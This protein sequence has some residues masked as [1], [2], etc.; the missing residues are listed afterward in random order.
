[1]G[2]VHHTLCLFTPPA[3]AGSHGAYLYRDGQAELTWV[4]G[5]IWRWFTQMQT[6]THPS[7][8]Q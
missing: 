7:T 4:T 6:I 2:L 8:N 5:Y 1:M 3:F